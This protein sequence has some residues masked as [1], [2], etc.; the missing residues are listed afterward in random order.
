MGFEI[1]CEGQSPERCGLGNGTRAAV[2][3]MVYERQCCVTRSASGAFLVRCQM[4]RQ[5]LGFMVCRI[6]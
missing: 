1:V 2:R 3:E 6:S 5:R 4:Q